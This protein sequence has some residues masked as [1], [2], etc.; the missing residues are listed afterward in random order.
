MIGHS[1]ASELKRAVILTVLDKEPAAGFF[2]L[3]FTDTDKSVT[4]TESMIDYSVLKSLSKPTGTFQDNPTEL[5]INQ[6]L[7]E[8]IT[9]N[10]PCL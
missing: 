9:C 2:R 4:F 10:K 5:T 7:S 6:G 8:L 1:D 3:P